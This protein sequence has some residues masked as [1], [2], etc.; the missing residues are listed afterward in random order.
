MAA[1]GKIRKHSTLLL[2]AVGGAI[3]LFVLGDLLG[4]SG[5]RSRNIPDIA[6]V[7]KEKVTYRE[8]SNKLEEQIE[9]YKQQYGQNIDNALLFQ[10]REEVFNDMVRQTVLNREYRSLRLQVSRAEMADMMTGLNIHPIIRQNF[11]DPQ[12]GVFN[13]ATVEQYL[14]KLEELDLQQQNQWFMIENLIKEQRMQ[15]KYQTMI[16]KAFFMPKEMAKTIQK[17]QNT[18]ANAKVFSVKY[19]SIPDEEITITDKDFQNY[20]N[21]HK[22]EYEQEASV[23]LDYVVF[24]V[25]PS[26]KDFEIASREIENIYNEFISIPFEDRAENFMFA[27][28]K[29]DIDFRADTGFVKR[30]TLPV[31]AD[32]IFEAPLGTVIGP[33]V[34]N[35]IYYIHKLLSR[36]NRPDSLKASHVLVAYK[37]AMRS[38][39][40]IT[41]TKEIAKEKADSLL[42]VL[43]NTDSTRFA[44]IAVEFSDDNSASTNGGNLDWFVDGQMVPQFNEAC[45]QGK[46]GDYFV[47]ESVFGFHIVHLLG[48]KAFETKIKIASMQYSI[49]ASSETRQMIYTEASRFAGESKSIEDFDNTIAEQGYVKRS[50]EFTRTSDF[51]IA[52]IQ[53]G[54]EIVRWAFGENINK[55]DISDVFDLIAENKNVVVLIR[56]IKT[57]GIPSLKDIKEQIEPLVIRDKKTEI[58][59]QRIIEAK[60]KANNIEAIASSFNETVVQVERASFASMNVPM[61]GPE[62]KIL[63]LIFALNKGVISEPIPVSAG[64]FVVQVEDVELP[65]EDNFMLEMFIANQKRNFTNRVGYDVYNALLKKAN[66]VENKVYFY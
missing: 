16:S 24:D 40:A 4:P 53:E 6:V 51:S 30:V 21:K 55:G 12:T 46:V 49:D 14:M 37:G 22:F 23:W 26:S 19:N 62:P 3:V 42:Q 63:G 20:Y 60:S 31:Q 32:S 29:S 50:S 13:P 2:I 41:R 38:D 43:K 15:T 10:I 58:L 17:Q 9:L 48:K 52:G 35:N 18:F 44:Q 11:T 27:D 57:K 56:D 34:D 66:L 28:I 25:L 36:E 47:V 54:R 8:Y 39:P 45:V 65:Q 64:V 33:Y 5:G 7:G 59:K 1:I 61:I